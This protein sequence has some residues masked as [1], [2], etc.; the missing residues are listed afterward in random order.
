[1]TRKMSPALWRLVANNWIPTELY[2]EP[3]FQYLTGEINKE[4]FVQRTDE[5]QSIYDGQREPF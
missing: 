2:G 3:L 5:I 4:K 1:M